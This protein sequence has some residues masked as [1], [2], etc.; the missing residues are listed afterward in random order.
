MSSPPVVA[1]P[2][3][4]VGTPVIGSC[5]ATGTGVLEAGG[6]V[7]DP[8]GL[9]TADADLELDGL[10]CAVLLAGVDG[11]GLQAGHVGL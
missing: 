8:D 4:T 6:G 11:L 5:C 2:M 10:A 7:G 1:I 3:T 9:A